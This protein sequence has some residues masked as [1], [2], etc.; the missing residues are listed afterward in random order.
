MIGTEYVYPPIPIRTMDW[1]ATSDSY[2]EGD[3]VGHGL[4]ELD[5]VKDLC[6]QFEQ[7]WLEKDVPGMRRTATGAWEVEPAKPTDEL[8]AVLKEMLAD[9]ETMNEPYR[10][11]AICER[12]R[13]AI[14]RTE[15][16][17]NV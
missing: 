8:L 9:A 13:A 3:P 16:V 14:K 11:E 4:T 10:N 7:L 1:Q 5:A 12:A 6:E 17:L 15:E 2:D